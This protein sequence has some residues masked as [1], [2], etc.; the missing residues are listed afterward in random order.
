[1]K[2]WGVFDGIWGIMHTYCCDRLEKKTRKFGGEGLP[3]YFGR[4]R[5]CL[6]DHLLNFQLIRFCREQNMPCASKVKVIA[7]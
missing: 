5:A 6:P 4:V 2:R 7:S 3:I 1:M